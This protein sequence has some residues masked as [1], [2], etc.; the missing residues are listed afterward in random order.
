MA[1]FES[2][3]FKPRFINFVLCIIILICCKND[4]NSLEDAI[5]EESNN[6]IFNTHDGPVPVWLQ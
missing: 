3:L 4:I 5:Y 1:V 2:M 6:F